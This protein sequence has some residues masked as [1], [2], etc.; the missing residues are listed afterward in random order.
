MKVLMV[1]G[2]PRVD[3]NTAVALREMEKFLRRRGLKR[4]PYRLETGTYAGALP[5]IPAP[6]RDAVYLTIW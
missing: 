6:K 2:S 4:R 5:A 1:N 3:G